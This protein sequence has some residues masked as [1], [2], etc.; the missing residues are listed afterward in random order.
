MAIRSYEQLKQKTQEGKGFN[1]PGAAENLQFLQNI[2]N[3]AAASAA[4]DPENNWMDMS[5]EQHETMFKRLNDKNILSADKQK[6]DSIDSALTYL[7]GFKQYMNTKQ[8]WQSNTPYEYLSNVI[9]KDQK[10]KEKLDKALESLDDVLE[11]GVKP[12]VQAEAKEEPEKEPEEKEEAAPKMMPDKYLEDLKA[13]AQEEYEDPEDRLENLKDCAAKLIAFNSRDTGAEFDPELLDKTSTKPYVMDSLADLK[14]NE[15]K[16]M[17]RTGATKKA[18]ARIR[19]DFAKNGYLPEKGGFQGLAPNAKKF[20]EGLQDKIGKK[21]FLEEEPYS[22]VET[23]EQLLAARASINAVR[24]SFRAKSLDKPVNLKAYQDTIRQMD[25]DGTIPD[26]LNNLIEKH[27][28][29]KVHD[30]ARTGHG[31]LLEDKVKEEIR[32]MAKTGDYKLGNVPKHFRPTVGERMKDIRDVMKDD[33]KWDEM[34]PEEKKGL[35][36]EYAL[37]QK[38]SRNPDGLKAV[39]GDIEEHNMKAEAFAK[40]ERF[41]QSV[42]NVEDVRKRLTNLSID[43]VTEAFEKSQA[44]EIRKAQEQEK[45]MADELEKEFEKN[46]G[47][48]EKK[49]EEPAG[50]VHSIN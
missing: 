49:K 50:P 27:G 44:D 18:E 21:D 20:T 46:Y 29:K 25:D 48:G 2:F 32:E 7:Y 6:Q 24:N 37:L 30:W 5:L 43:E 4:K 9:C 45:K 17:F 8:V 47:Q 34:T 1:A 31:G 3:R 23:Y 28:E 35:I 40:S 16:E 42:T 15:L 22:Q 12:E 26:A 38:Q 39:M 10:E 14:E 41:N 36:S 33:E 11:L 19:E 13:K